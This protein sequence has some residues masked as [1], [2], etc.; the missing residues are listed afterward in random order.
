M[1]KI[2]P[3]LLSVLMLTSCSGLQFGVNELITPPRLT[4]QQSEIYDAIEL[5]VGT[6]AFKFRYPRRGEN[7]SACVFHD[8][9]HDGDEEAIAFY[10]LTVNGTTSSWMSI[11]DEDKNGWK[12]RNQ[13]PGEGGEIDFVSFAPVENENSSNIIV[14][15]NASGQEG[16]ICKVY[17]FANDAVTLSFEGEY[18]EVMIKDVDGNGL[19]E[20]LLCTK[21]RTR[22]GIMSLVKYR[23]GR[24]VKT[25][26][27][28][29][30][31]AMTG[32]EQLTYGKFTSG[33]SAVFADIYL[34]SDE[35]TTFV[36]AVDER[37]SVISELRSEDIGIFE[38]FE[39]PVP[40]LCSNDVNGDGLIDIPISILLPGYEES[41]EQQP[42]YL[43]K[44]KTVKQGELENASSYIVNFAA[45]YQFKMPESWD[46][47]VTVKRLSEANEW[48]FCI[49]NKSLHESTTELMR[50]RV[51]SPSSY[52]DKLETAKFETVAQKGINS[53]Q[54]YIPSGS[55]PGYS[56]TM[57]QAKNLLEL[58]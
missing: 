21:G 34:G 32:F 5:A 18:D 17:G 11:L 19:D 28:E 2:I 41:G 39:R 27:V 12:S 48:S 6:D 58:L 36:A 38:S 14:G 9:D 44:Y 15:W 3:A 22:N 57:Q 7:L 4:A 16:N 47:K 13:I 51:I 10:E 43:T 1:K 24:I 54:I 45:G 50:I 46:E 29:L 42:L 26:E 35:M 23:S 30:P 31:S 25:S 53:Y 20:L 52:H 40:T 37:R 8:L 55:Y 33:L 49:F 56:I